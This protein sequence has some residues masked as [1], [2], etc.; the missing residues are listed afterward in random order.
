[1]SDARRR[2]SPMT[3][4]CSRTSC[5]KSFAVIGYDED[6]GAIVDAFRFQERE[7]LADDGVGRG[8]LAVVRIGIA[9]AKRL[10]RLVRDVRLVDV[11]EIEERFCGM[12]VDPLLRARL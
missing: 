4:C 2:C 10:R 1:M 3:S 6:D 7:Q 5:A 12:R 8:D 11:K 9:A